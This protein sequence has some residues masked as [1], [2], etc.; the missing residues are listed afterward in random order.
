MK[1]AVKILKKK[2]FIKKEMD[3][4]LGK[5]LSDEI[6]Q[7]AHEKLDGFLKRYEDLPEGVH[8]HTDNY[9]FPSSAIYLSA[10]EKT[11]KETAYRIIEDSASALTNK[12][13]KIM[14]GILAI[15]GMKSLF[16][17]IWRPLC[18]KMYGENNGFE[19]V[20]YPCEKDEFRMDIVSCPFCHY[21]MELGCPELTKVFCEND[22]RVYGNL[23]GI[24][25]KRTST[26]GK[27]ADRCDFYFR[28]KRN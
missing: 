23:K 10:I 20:Y 7:N 8:L 19:N 4:Q 16:V 25:F 24:E 5:E 18:N 15:P 11:E 27:G 14:N 28:R 17:R 12:A 2:S 6:W 26:L 1:K 13:A 9:I 22:D 21:F 3:R